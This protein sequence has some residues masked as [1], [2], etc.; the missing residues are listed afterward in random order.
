LRN[1]GNRRNVGAKL[2]DLLPA[3]G[4]AH[5]VRLGDLLNPFGSRQPDVVGGRPEVEPLVPLNCLSLRFG[6]FVHD[7]MIALPLISFRAIRSAS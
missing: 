5:N 3:I 1:Q 7:G 6:P 4:A 2:G